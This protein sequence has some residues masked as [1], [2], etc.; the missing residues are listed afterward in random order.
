MRAAKR[1]KKKVEIKNFKKKEVKKSEKT[2]TEKIETDKAKIVQKIQRHQKGVETTMAISVFV[3]TV[4]FNW[5]HS[6]RGWSN[7]NL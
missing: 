6:N 1:L 5:N 7:I 4:R 2:K 3:F